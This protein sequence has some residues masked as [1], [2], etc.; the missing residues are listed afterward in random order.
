M[1]EFIFQGKVL[2][3]SLSGSGIVEFSFGGSK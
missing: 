2:V 3:S 1:F